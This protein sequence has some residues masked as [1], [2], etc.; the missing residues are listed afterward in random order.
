FP[1]IRLQQLKKAFASARW[2]LGGSALGG[3]VADL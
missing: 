3:G 1:H 2:R